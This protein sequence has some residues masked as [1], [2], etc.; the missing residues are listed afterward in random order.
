MI[1]NERFRLR[2]RD[3]KT[4][5][6]R[7][8]PAASEILLLPYAVPVD[9]M[10]GDVQRWLFLDNG[11]DADF[12]RAGPEDFSLS[13]TVLLQDCGPDEVRDATHFWTQVIDQRTLPVPQG[14]HRIAQ[15]RWKECMRVLQVAVVL[16]VVACLREEAVRDD[17]GK[18]EDVGVAWLEDAR[19]WVVIDWLAEFEEG[20]VSAALA[21]DG[22]AFDCCP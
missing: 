1:R 17:E 7:P 22:S 15:R 2:R 11:R 13:A 16:G 20:L 6:L 18:W 21:R 12:L 10:V 4:A 5:A 14:Y 19:R 3:N 8:R 9:F